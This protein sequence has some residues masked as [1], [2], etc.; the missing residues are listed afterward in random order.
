MLWTQKDNKETLLSLV[1]RRFLQTDS[2][3]PQGLG[4]VLSCHLVLVLP[5]GQRGVDHVDGALLPHLAVVQS[6]SRH[7]GHK[8]LGGQRDELHYPGVRGLQTR[9]GQVVGG[10]GVWEDD[11]IQY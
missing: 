9:A 1:I 6:I 7:I 8:L 10:H 4:Q 5:L 3:L 2:L 11:Y